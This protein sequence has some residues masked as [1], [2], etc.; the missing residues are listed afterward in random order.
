M[1]QQGQGCGHMLLI[2]GP[3]DDA[4]RELRHRHQLRHGGEAMLLG[5][6]EGLPGRLHPFRVHVHHPHD[7]EQI[8]VRQ[9]FTGVNHGPDPHAYDNNTN[10]SRTH[11][12]SSF[13]PYRI[14]LLPIHH[15]PFPGI[16]PQQFSL[17][18]NKYIV[19]NYLP[20]T[21]LTG[22]MLFLSD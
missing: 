16:F 6:P 11:F 17:S 14:L 1:P 7:L 22:G 12:S 5:Y 2:H 13:L 3:V 4:V 9:C 10:W 8:R 19:L 21:E 15:K 20:M 18:G